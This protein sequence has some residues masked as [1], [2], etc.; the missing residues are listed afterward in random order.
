MLFENLEIKSQDLPELLGKQ[1]EAHPR[2]YLKL[3]VISLLILFLFIG[4]GVSTIWMSGNDLIAMIATAVWAVFFLL[5]L[6]FE[7]KAFPI[8]GYLVREKD[9]SYR[10]GLIFREV[11]TVP[12]NRVQHSEVSNGPIERVMDLSTLKIYTAGGSSS[13]LSIHGL[14]PRDAEKIKEW[15]TQK[16]A[17]HV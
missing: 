12:Y 3:R 15:L 7:W 10:S 16:T 2:R 1:F 5:F 9:I 4:I 6:F 11:V 17:Q 13:D 14:D 8:R